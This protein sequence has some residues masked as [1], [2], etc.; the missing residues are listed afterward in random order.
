LQPQIH[1]SLTQYCNFVMHIHMYICTLM[2]FIYNVMKSFYIALWQKK[3]NS[4]KSTHSHSFKSTQW[5]LHSHSSPLMEYPSMEVNEWAIE[6][7]LTFWPAKKTW[8]WPLGVEAPWWPVGAAVP[9][10]APPVPCPLWWKWVA[11]ITLLYSQVYN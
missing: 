11:F 6:W 10:E 1:V 5:I 2:K 7:P 8:P 9:W 3:L 4:L